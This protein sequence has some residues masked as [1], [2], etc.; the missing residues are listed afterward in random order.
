[1]PSMGLCRAWGHA[2]GL[3]CPGPLNPSSQQCGIILTT[4]NGKEWDMA[5]TF[6]TSAQI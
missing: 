5:K 1:M 3:Q 4:C 6:T 2:T